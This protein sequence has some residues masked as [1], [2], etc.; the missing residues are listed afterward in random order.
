M[1]AASALF[2]ALELVVSATFVSPFCN[3]ATAAQSDHISLAGQWR[4]Q[5]D[6]ENAGM[7]GQWFERLLKDK[8]RLPGSLPAQGIG[9][10][11]AVETKWTG[12]I[13]DNPVARQMLHSLLHYVNSS[14][15]KPAVA[16]SPAEVRSLMVPAH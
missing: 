8:I 4:F 3:Q 11:V 16:L 13:V 9:D 10:D 14:S 7:P 2:L 12:D 5:L 1:K 6:R 15:F